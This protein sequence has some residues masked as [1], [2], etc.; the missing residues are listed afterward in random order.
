M[1]KRNAKCGNWF[2]PYIGAKKEEE[3]RRGHVVWTIT[4]GLQPQR[5]S[6]GD[7]RAGKKNL[8]KRPDQKVG[9]RDVKKAGGVIMAQVLR[10]T[11]N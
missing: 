10:T 11:F 1:L 8:E 3:S 6:W 5:M 9:L 4:A 2:H 7:F